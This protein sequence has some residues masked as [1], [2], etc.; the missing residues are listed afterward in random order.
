MQFQTFAFFLDKKPSRF[1]SAEIRIV[2]GVDLTRVPAHWIFH[3]SKSLRG[4]SFRNRPSCQSSY[5]KSDCGLF[6]IRI[7]CSADTLLS[8][9]LLAKSNGLRGSVLAERKCTGWEEVYWLRGSVLCHYSYQTAACVCSDKTLAK[10]C[11]VFRSV[12]RIPCRIICDAPNILWKAVVYKRYTVRTMFYF[13][14]RVCGAIQMLHN[15]VGGGGGGEVGGCKFSRKKELCNVHLNELLMCYVTQSGWRCTDRRR[16]ALRRC[17]HGPTL[18]AL[19]G[20]GSVK[21][22]VAKSIVSK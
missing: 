4:R 19:R 6:T 1:Q 2:I 15:A 10:L 3:S 16:S 5:R 12:I 9:C 13:G 7:A 22:L 21:F 14:C 8:F 17:T 18:F 20:G 11:L